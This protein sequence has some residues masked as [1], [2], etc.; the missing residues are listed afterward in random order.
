MARRPEP[1]GRTRRR[2]A[3]PEIIRYRPP[4]RRRRRVFL[5]ITVVVTTPLLTSLLLT[6]AFRWLAPPT[7][8]FMVLHRLAG[9]SVE[10][11]WVD[12]DGISPNIPI[13]A[14]AAEDQ[15]FPAHAGFDLES[16]QQAM[17]ENRQRRSPRGASTISQQ[18]AK[19]LYLWPGKSLVRKAL[20]AYFTVL[21]EALWPK[22]RILEVYLN[23]AE[24]GPGIF[25]VEA[26]SRAYFG[27]PAARV[28]PAQAALLAAV[29]P[30]PKLLHAGSPSEYVRGRA[31]QI[32]DQVRLLGGSHYLARL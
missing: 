12:Y 17:R 26:A 1:V 19:N 28:D 27:R 8:A 16:I 6:L 23:I 15:K 20:E 11:A 30:N 32:Q 31:R 24:F 9:S 18:V 5:V 4:R 10:Y 2:P 22:R 13:A 25:G 3:V 14:V 7:S 29:L 21:I